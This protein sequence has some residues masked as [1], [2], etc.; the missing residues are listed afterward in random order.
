MKINNLTISSKRMMAG[1][2]A[3][4]TVST[5]AGCAKTNDKVTSSS[6][7]IV[8]VSDT[9]SIEK[10]SSE[11]VVEDIKPVDLLEGKYH[12]L[13]DEEVNEIYDELN[14]YTDYSNRKKIDITDFKTITA[15]SQKIYNCYFQDSDY[16]KEDVVGAY[17]MFL[18]YPL[19][20]KENAARYFDMWDI[21]INFQSDEIC[22]TLEEGKVTEPFIETPRMSYEIDNCKSTNYIFEMLNSSYVVEHYGN[23]TLRNNYDQVQNVKDNLSMYASNYSLCF[24]ELVDSDA[25]PLGSEYDLNKSKWVLWYMLYKS[26]VRYNSYNSEQ[27]NVYILL[28]ENNNMVFGENDDQPKTVNYDEYI[29]SL[30]IKIKDYTDQYMKDV[31]NNNYQYSLDMLTYDGQKLSA[32]KTLTK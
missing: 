6:S 11:V 27:P 10:V 2:M 7:A 13:P 22:K 24:N 31:N 30:D 20:V 3:A 8:S 19:P 21:I 23:I 32:D 5:M 12:F 29:E 17:L 15:I 16:T 4:V 14:N 28:D 1:M 9:S 18:G 25:Y 26:S